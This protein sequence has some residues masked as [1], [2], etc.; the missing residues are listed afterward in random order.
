MDKR[1]QESDQEEQPESHSKRATLAKSGGVSPVYE[2]KRSAEEAKQSAG[3]SNGGPRMGVEAP[4]EKNRAPAQNDAGTV[5]CC[6]PESSE[7][8]FDNASR[9]PERDDIEQQMQWVEVK[10]RIGEQPPVLGVELTVGRQCAQLE[11]GAL[12]T[13]GVADDLDAKDCY[14]R[15]DEDDR[16]SSRSHTETKNSTF[17]G[18]HINAHASAAGHHA[19]VVRRLQAL[20]GR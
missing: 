10:E 1:Y 13:H 12:V 5:D 17:R 9:P 18:R 8:P 14:E 11:Q 15:H 6:G 7:A 16:S 4:N 19:P 3:C 20:V 2:H